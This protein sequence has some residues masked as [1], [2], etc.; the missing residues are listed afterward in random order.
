[1]DLGASNS[2]LESYKRRSTVKIER[3]EVRV[4][5]ILGEKSW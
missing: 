3:K 2:T 5:F 4:T 1:M